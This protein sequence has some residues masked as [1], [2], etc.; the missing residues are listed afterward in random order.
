[1]AEPGKESPANARD[2]SVAAVST[3]EVMLGSIRHWFDALDTCIKGFMWACSTRECRK[4][5]SAAGIFPCSIAAVSLTKIF[6][7]ML[8]MSDRGC[9]GAWE[10]PVTA[11]GAI[12]DKNPLPGVLSIEAL[13]LSDPDGLGAAVVVIP[14]VPGMS[15]PVWRG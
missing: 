15:L 6:C 13:A 7:R 4:P 10:S 14:R 11:V 5:K 1:M 9:A 3:A 8:L 2:M 12:D